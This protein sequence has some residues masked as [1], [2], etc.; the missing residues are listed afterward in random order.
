ME[1]WRALLNNY[2]SNISSSELVQTVQW[3]SY[4][5]GACV[6]A[7]CELQESLESNTETVHMWEENERPMIL[8]F[9]IYCAFTCCLMLM[10]DAASLAHRAL[11]LS[12]GYTKGTN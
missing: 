3:L 7:S 2:G 1:E 4:S 9:L 10:C 5:D 11:Q 6:L 8:N 12:S